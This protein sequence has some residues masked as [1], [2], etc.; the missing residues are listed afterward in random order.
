MENMKFAKFA[1]LLVLIVVLGGVATV[2]IIA[3]Y[4]VE[5]GQI[6]RPERS[7]TA[8]SRGV[9]PRA[10]A[11]Q[12][13]LVDHTCTDLS[14]IPEAWIDQARQNSKM[15][16]GYTSHGSQLIDGLGMIESDRGAAYSVAVEWFLP[17][18]EDALCIRKAATY[19]PGD[20][21]P[22]VPGA[23]S[24]NPEI[25]VV[26]YAWCGQPGADDWRGLLDD[27]IAAME[28]LEQ[29][30]PGV[31]FVYMTGHTQEGDCSGCNRHQFNQ[32]LRDYVL[33]H[34]KVL[35]DFADLDL[36]RHGTYTANTY[37][38]PSWCANPGASTPIEH[39]GWGGGDWNNPCG[40]TTAESCVNKGNALWWLLA[41]IAGWDGG[42]ITPASQ[43]VFL[44]LIAISTL[45]PSPTIRASSISRSLQVAATP[46][47]ASTTRK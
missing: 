34:N 2:S 1:M 41:R 12:A 28:A 46:C 4:P 15:Y 10:A 22:T 38:C 14:A 36:W 17:Q 43:P 33:A 30:Y 20:F 32:A 18:K 45:A 47:T 3:G 8:P 37:A 25:N 9:A 35:Y 31:T 6:H 42:A 26:M 11:S 19:D 7:P 29:R 24:A 5:D 21:F 44:P 23:L 27:Y 13:I 39:E 40:H 16:Y